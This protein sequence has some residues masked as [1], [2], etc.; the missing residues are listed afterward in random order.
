M[1]RAT[2]WPVLVS[3]RQLPLILNGAPLLLS[4]MRLT[5]PRGFREMLNGVGNVPPCQ[6]GDAR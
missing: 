1:A 6:G 4:R 3:K 2:W 5:D